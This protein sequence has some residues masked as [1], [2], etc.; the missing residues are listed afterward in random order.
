MEITKILR[1]PNV[2]ATKLGISLDDILKLE[3][4]DSKMLGT[5]TSKQTARYLQVLTKIED[6]KIGISGMSEIIVSFESSDIEVDSLKVTRELY[7]K[8]LAKLYHELNAM[9]H[10][11]NFELSYD[12]KL[13]NIHAW[14]KGNT[15]QHTITLKSKNKL[16]G[17]ELLRNLIDYKLLHYF[18]ISLEDPNVFNI[19]NDYPNSDVIGNLINA[20]AVCLA[21]EGAFIKK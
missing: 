14:F 20:I 15:N 12:N 10:S 21:E 9:M 7:Y 19:I 13:R 4:P 3:N 11:Y 1:T 8:V 5:L 6:V 17:T 16:V 18:I 2:V